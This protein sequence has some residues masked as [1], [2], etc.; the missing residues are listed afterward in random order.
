MNTASPRGESPWQFT[1]CVTHPHIFTQTHTHFNL[2]AQTM[3]MMKMSDYGVETGHAADAVW[4]GC[5]HAC[6]MPG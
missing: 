1:K 2:H 3:R 6:L 5:V 4:Q